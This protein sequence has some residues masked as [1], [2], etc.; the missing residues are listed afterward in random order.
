MD[1]FIG[2][3]WKQKLKIGGN[4]LQS[5]IYKARKGR[6]RFATPTSLATEL[7]LSVLASTLLSKIWG[8][9]QAKIGG[10]SVDSLRLFQ[11]VVWC[12]NNF[13]VTYYCH[14][15]CH[16]TAIR[17]VSSTNICLILF[18]LSEQ[19]SHLVH[20]CVSW[21]S[22]RLLFAQNIPDLKSLR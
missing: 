14:L 3:K 2:G 22:P 20:W 12:R 19:Q 18:G 17:R 5:V 10:H 4:F 15:K 9:R 16:S 11:D 21:N 7:L 6:I 13:N 1:K 8:S